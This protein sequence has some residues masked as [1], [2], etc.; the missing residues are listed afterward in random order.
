MNAREEAASLAENPLPTVLT[1]QDR[2]LP[3]MLWQLDLQIEDINK[4][5]REVK[6]ERERIMARALQTGIMEDPYCRIESKSKYFRKL[7]SDKFKEAFPEAWS[8][9]VEILT[10]DYQVMIKT[11]GKNIGVTLADKLV[12]KTGKDAL[13]LCMTVEESKVYTVVEKGDSEPHP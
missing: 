1:D 2:L 13:A 8:R 6:A 7:D 12:G 10:H 11:A 9:A 5:L 3:S 4:M